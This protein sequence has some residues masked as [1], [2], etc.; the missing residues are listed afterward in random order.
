MPGTYDKEEA[1][2]LKDYNFDRAALGQRGL[3]YE[4]LDQLTIEIILGVR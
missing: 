2:Q 3:D 1:Q 4:R